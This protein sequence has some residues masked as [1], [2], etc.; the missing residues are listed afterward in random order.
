[1]E[2]FVHRALETYKDPAFPIFT[3]GLWILHIVTY[4][5][6]ALPV[7]WFDMKKPPWADPYKIQERVADN[8]RLFWPSLGLFFLNGA[9]LVGASALAWPLMHWCGLHVGPLPPWYTILWQVVFFMYLDDFLYYFIHRVLHIP[10][11]FKR[12][13][14]LHHSVK[15]PWGINAHYMHPIELLLTGFTVLAGPVILGA[16]LFPLFAWIVVR[17]WTGVAGHCGYE[18]RFDPMKI[19]PGYLGNVFHDFHHS[20]CHGNYSGG[21]GWVDGLFG[22]WAN[23]YKERDREIKAQIKVAREAKRAGQQ[24]AGA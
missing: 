14:Y 22:S 11:L 24:S 6:M 4:L 5:A 3:L 1:M 17:Q 16:H 13:H 23:G 8:R 9:L 12:I 21:L 2:D 10:W 15:T 18:L 20:Q 7:T 19:F